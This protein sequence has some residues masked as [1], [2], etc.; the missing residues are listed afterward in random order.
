MAPLV[1]LAP[2]AGEVAG[3]VDLA[4]CHL[5]LA[6]HAVID[7]DGVRVVSAQALERDLMGWQPTKLARLRDLDLDW[8]AHA[9]S[10]ALMK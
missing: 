10:V 6:R 4:R 7:V 3:E 8:G 5:V 9:A 2:V 1:A